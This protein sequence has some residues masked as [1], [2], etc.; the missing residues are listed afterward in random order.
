MKLLK[1]ILSTALLLST[2]PGWSETTAT[3]AKQ[4]Y[5]AEA[6]F[7]G[8]P[9][10]RFS[11]H[12]QVNKLVAATAAQQACATAHPGPHS[13]TDYCE[14]VSLNN[15]P[16]TTVADIRASLPDSPHPLFLWRYQ[17]NEATV[18]LAGSVHILKR[19]FYPLPRQ[20]Q[21]AFELSD[22][23]VLE[24]DMTALSP[25][26]L[27]A[28]TMQYAVLDN[29]QQLADVLD[30]ETFNALNQVTAQYGLPLNQLRPFKPG[31]ITQQL[32]VLALMA[33]GY[34]P[35]QGVESYFTAQAAEKNILALESLDFQLDLLM[36]QPLPLQVAMVR[37]TLDQMDDFETFTAELIRAWLSGDDERFYQAFAAQSGESEASRAF[38]KQ[39]LDDRNVGMADEIERYLNSDSSYFVV[40]GAAHYTGKN[41][42]IDLLEARG[43]RGERI[44]SDQQI[45]P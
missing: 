8:A 4:G 12:G 25:A 36:N 39:L 29:N 44:Y 33:V 6:V 38:L 26:E 14:L 43:Y 22:N 45:K 28:K 13:Q 10:R 15:V 30:E 35:G 18:F 27:Q 37:D 19:G 11:V 23:L 2:A 31:F 7:S 9:E 1:L 32:A 40:A 20:Y 21:H 41:N 42:I 17:H 24:V 5:S 16:L 3:P 34:D